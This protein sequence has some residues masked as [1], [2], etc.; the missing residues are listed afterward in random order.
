MNDD[1]DGGDVISEVQCGDV[2]RLAHD[3]VLVW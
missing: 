2:G 3:G 1:D